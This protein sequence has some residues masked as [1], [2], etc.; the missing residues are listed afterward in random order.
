MDSE[1][2]DELSVKPIPPGGN[3]LALYRKDVAGERGFNP[4]SPALRN[5]LVGLVAGK[6]V[7]ARNVTIQR[8]S[9]YSLYM[10]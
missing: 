6:V 3:V 8:T 7:V 9:S 2:C 1:S 10:D 5:G 4:N